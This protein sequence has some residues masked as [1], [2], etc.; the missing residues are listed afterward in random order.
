M[1]VHKVQFKNT[2]PLAK[3]IMILSMLRDGSSMRS[4]NGIV[5]VRINTVTELLVIAGHKRVRAT[6]SGPGKWCVS[7]LQ[8]YRPVVSAILRIAAEFRAGG[9][10]RKVELV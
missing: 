4:I 8:N 9:R 2:L 6:V 7:P 5:D 1:P 10:S 3:R